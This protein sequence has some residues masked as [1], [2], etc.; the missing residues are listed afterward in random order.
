[1]SEHG[2]A[3]G[4]LGSKMGAQGAA[5]ANGG[6]REAAQLQALVGAG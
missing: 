5:Q 6:T 2:K 3:M 4:E 1:M